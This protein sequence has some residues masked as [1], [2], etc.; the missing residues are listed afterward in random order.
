MVFVR[1][2]IYMYTS[3]GTSN[4]FCASA[5]V[6]I[7]TSL[8]ASTLHKDICELIWHI[9]PLLLLRRMI[10]FFIYLNVDFLPLNCAPKL[11]QVVVMFNDKYPYHSWEGTE[12]RLLFMT[13]LFLNLLVMNWFSANN[14]R[15]Q[16]NLK[17]TRNIKGLG[18]WWGSCEP[19]E[20]FL[21]VNKIWFTVFK[22]ISIL[23]VRQT[24]NPCCDL[25]LTA[26][27]MI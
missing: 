3:T 11:A 10:C 6:L 17:H 20:N 16:D 26:G 24:L 9:D 12:N 8:A 23:C 7:F 19:C 4:S 25:T 14:F 22:I 5:L 13:T 15:N 1:F 21:H 27:I 2:H 18:R